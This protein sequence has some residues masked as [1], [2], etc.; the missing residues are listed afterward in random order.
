MLVF[1]IRYLVFFS[2]IGVVTFLTKIV[3]GLDLTVLLYLKVLLEKNYVNFPSVL[4]K[5]IGRII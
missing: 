4:L 1:I 3:Y 2:V 5:T